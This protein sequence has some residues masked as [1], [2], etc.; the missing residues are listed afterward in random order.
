MGLLDKY[1][2]FN[3]EDLV[4][5][6]HE[7]GE[8]FEDLCLTG[9]NRSRTLGICSFVAGVIALF[10]SQIGVGMTLLVLFLYFGQ[11]L[12]NFHA[13][14]LMTRYARVLAHLNAKAPLVARSYKGERERGANG[15]GPQ[16]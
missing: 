8:A 15:E 13:E 2:M 6:I 1:S 4:A 12:A 11:Q 5:N 3:F 10:L 9:Q 14:M 16:G 7:R